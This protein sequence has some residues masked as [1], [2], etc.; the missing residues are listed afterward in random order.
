M[1]AAARLRA[2][3]SRP[4]PELPRGP[5]ADPAM[6]RALVALAGDPAA[7]CDRALADAILDGEPVV[8]V[9]A[10]AFRALRPRDVPRFLRDLP[11]PPG[12]RVLVP[13]SV[14]GAPIAVGTHDALLAE[15]NA[16]FGA[17]FD[18]DDFAPF[19]RDS[20]AL[21][22]VRLRAR[23]RVRVSAPT[24]TLELAP[25]AEV[26][27]T[28]GWRHTRERLRL[29]AKQAGFRLGAWLEQDGA[30]LAVLDLPARPR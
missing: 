6:A 9:D 24:P 21:F 27:A 8:E 5:V 10:A 25:G 28:L 3:F 30:A 18:P 13:V 19:P 29:L 12:A 26:R 15:V 11:R 16:R 2:W 20:P 4:L 1:D 17:D 23:R 7:A 14:D 22:E